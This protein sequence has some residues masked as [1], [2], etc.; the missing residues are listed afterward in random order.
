[1][2]TTG[3]YRILMV[4]DWPEDAEAMRQALA[5]VPEVKEF[6]SARHA[7]EALE[8]LG[9]QR[10]RF[11]LILMDQMWERRQVPDP[12]VLTDAE[13]RLPAV[14]PPD[15]DYQGF[16][17]MR[18][19]RA[20]HV[21]VPIIFCTR[22]PDWRRGLEVTK[23][24]AFTYWDKPLLLNNPDWALYPLEEGAVDRGFVRRECD[25]R[26]LMWDRQAQEELV[27]R[28][29]LWGR[30][31][32][33]IV[34]ALLEQAAARGLLH[35]DTR[36]VAQLDEAIIPKVTAQFREPLTE[37][38]LLDFLRGRG[39][40]AK[41]VEHFAPFW[42]VR[43]GSGTL[44]VILDPAAQQRDA[45]LPLD[46][47]AATRSWHNTQPVIAPAESHLWALGPTD[48]YW[49]TDKLCAIAVAADGREWVPFPSLAG[50][51]GSP[52]ATFWQEL[53]T[54]CQGL[55]DFSPFRE[56][57]A[58]L[59]A[60][61]AVGAKE[62]DSLPESRLR[63]LPFPR[64]LIRR[65]ILGERERPPLQQ[66]LGLHRG[67]PG[68]AELPTTQLNEQ[69]RL[70][71]AVEV[72]RAGWATAFEEETLQVVL[73]HLARV[74]DPTGLGER[75]IWLGCDFLHVQGGNRLTVWPRE[76]DLLLLAPQGLLLLECKDSVGPQDLAKGHVQVKDQRERIWCS[77]KGDFG[78]VFL[79]P[80]LEARLNQPDAVRRGGRIAP[81]VLEVVPSG[82]RDRLEQARNR[83]EALQAVQEHYRELTSLF[84][85]P[86]LEIKPGLLRPDN[87]R[88][89]PVVV[90][91]VVVPEEAA[92]V[93]GRGRALPLHLLPIGRDLPDR[94][95][96]WLQLPAAF[97]KEQLAQVRAALDHL[98]LAGDETGLR[99]LHGFVAQER[100]TDPTGLGWQ[101]YHGRAEW[102]DQPQTL[103]VRIL[104][105]PVKHDLC[106]AFGRW[107]VTVLRELTCDLRWLDARG[108]PAQQRRHVCRLALALHGK[109]RFLQMM[110]SWSTSEWLAAVLALW[111]LGS[112]PPVAEVLGSSAGT[113]APIAQQLLPGTP[114]R[115]GWLPGEPE[116]RP[117]ATA[118][119]GE[120]ERKGLVAVLDVLRQLLATK[121]ELTSLT[122]LLQETHAQAADLR[123]PTPDPQIVVRAVQERLAALTAAGN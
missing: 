62:E 45:I 25:R 50:R 69:L 43:E 56:R 92:R 44:Y 49:D 108:L 57:A 27:A 106:Q 79:Q 116:L 14:G 78:G 64:E 42:H 70:L 63:V 68:P 35:I 110:Q 12:S 47:S 75:C 16:G 55:T 33:A 66:L 19:L 10:D 117:A 109:I 60:L 112:D 81:D 111:Q 102:I 104:K 97:T 21:T 67:D 93:A 20:N 91:F 100:A 94:L 65:G 96:R 98:C 2:A 118:L 18:F 119:S 34:V 48:P 7:A 76:F 120:A 122:E 26:G 29:A 77:R 114:W 52:G 121:K 61:Y 123:H 113:P 23:A 17:I 15:W 22:V 5:R 8:M 4:D 32:P 83:S 73:E 39:L 37:A 38:D 28:R 36:A 53:R 85:N 31:W 1:M 40:V 105:P 103:V 58:S 88:Q 9:P 95:G 84:T 107:P 86:S 59:A 30:R 11:D 54:V 89:V 71:P 82:L 101:V 41:Q 13:G 87:R 115:Y 51:V 99:E 90:G 74:P 46:W 24:G 80:V 3:R 6:A 72:R